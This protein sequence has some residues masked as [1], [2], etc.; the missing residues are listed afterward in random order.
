M[1]VP[2]AAITNE[3]RNLSM[4]NA[5]DDLTMVGLLWM[6]ASANTVRHHLPNGFGRIHTLSSEDD[7]QPS[8][9][10]SRKNM[11][12]TKGQTHDIQTH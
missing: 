12:T 5:V 1:T 8:P 10:D 11:L 3:P 7:E 2:K 6:G 9:K 4:T